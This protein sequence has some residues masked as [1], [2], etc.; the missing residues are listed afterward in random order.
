MKRKPLRR[1]CSCL[2]GSS[3]TSMLSRIRMLRVLLLTPVFR[4]WGT[5]V[6]LRMRLLLRWRRSTRILLIA[7]VRVV[8][9]A[10]IGAARLLRLEALRVRL[11]L[12]LGILLGMLHRVHLWMM[13]LLWLLRLSCI[14]MVVT[15]ELHGTL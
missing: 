10:T 12:L 6:L 1:S 11:L 3:D 15:M 8:R 14:V 4:L 5:S 7:V 9:W 13:R 2:F